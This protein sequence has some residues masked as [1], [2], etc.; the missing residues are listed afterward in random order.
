MTPGYRTCLPGRDFT[1]CWQPVRAHSRRGVWWVSDQQ[2]HTLTGLPDCSHLC[3]LSE[4]KS[5]DSTLRTDW[6]CLSVPLPKV[7]TVNKI[8]FLSFSLLLV[9]FC[10]NW[11]IHFICV[12]VVACMYVCMYVHM[13]KCLVFMEIR[14]T[15]SPGTVADG[16]ELLCRHWGPKL[17]PL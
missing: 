13:P 2:D 16:Y 6:T 8:P 11:F 14:S 5:H 3:P 12:W 10:K 9:S 4:P 17:G 1:Q 7:P 15:E